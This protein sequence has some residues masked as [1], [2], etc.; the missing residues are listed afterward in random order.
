[1]SNIRDSINSVIQLC[2]DHIGLCSAKQDGAW[3]ILD[4]V[5]SEE[6]GDV[7]QESSGLPFDYG[8]DSCPGSSVLPQ[9]HG[10]YTPFCCTVSKLGSS[11]L[12]LFVCIKFIKAVHIH[13]CLPRMSVVSC[14]MSYWFNLFTAKH[15]MLCSPATISLQMQYL[16][17]VLI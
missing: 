14:L 4:K 12:W 7:Q 1:M 6:A 5:W 11:C 15:I 17:T 2:I 3:C 9:S 13:F 16:D 10:W 8:L